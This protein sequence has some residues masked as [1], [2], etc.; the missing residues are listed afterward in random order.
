MANEICWGQSDIRKHADI[1]HTA[2]ALPEAYEKLP[3][4][5]ALTQPAKIVAGF[6][7]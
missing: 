7:I 6:L 3:R 1:N 2:L 5:E 4:C